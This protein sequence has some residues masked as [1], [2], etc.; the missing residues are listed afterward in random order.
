MPHYNSD[1]MLSLWSFSVYIDVFN[2]QFTAL[3]ILAK[4]Q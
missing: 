1:F 4:Q 2:R 3:V